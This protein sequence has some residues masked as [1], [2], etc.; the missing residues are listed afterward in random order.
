MLISSEIESRIH[1]RLVRLS[2]ETKTVALHFMT[3][4]SI[5]FATWVLMRDALH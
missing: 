5:A 2:N 3:G 4:V 1:I